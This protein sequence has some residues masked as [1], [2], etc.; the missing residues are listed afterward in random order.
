MLKQD[1]HMNFIEA[2]LLNTSFYELSNIKAINLVN[3]YTNQVGGDPSLEAF[4][5]KVESTLKNREIFLKISSSYEQLILQKLDEAQPWIFQNICKLLS[6]SESDKCT[7]GVSFSPDV[8][9][10]SNL[11]KYVSSLKERRNDLKAYRS[12][13][14]IHTLN[15]LHLTGT[16]KTSAVKFSS[17]KRLYEVL[18]SINTYDMVV[19][20]NAELTHAL[21]FKDEYF[22][23]DIQLKIIIRIAQTIFQQGSASATNFLVNL[24]E[25]IKDSSLLELIVSSFRGDWSDQHYYLFQ[26]LHAVDPDL[27]S[28]IQSKGDLVKFDIIPLLNKDL[29]EKELYNLFLLD[30]K[31]VLGNLSI[32]KNMPAALYRG[33]AVEKSIIN[34]ENSSLIEQ[35]ANNVSELN[36]YLFNKPSTTGMK[37][38]LRK[39]AKHGF[40]CAAAYLYNYFYNKINT[41]KK[42]SHLEKFSDLE[43]LAFIALNVNKILSIQGEPYIVDKNPSQTVK[44]W[45]D[46]A[47]VLPNVQKWHLMSFRFDKKEPK[48]DTFLD[49]Y[50]LSYMRPT[51]EISLDPYFGAN[52][53]YNP[54]DERGGFSLNT[55]VSL[56]KA[57]K[58]NPWKS[59]TFECAN[60]AAALSLAYLFGSDLEAA[61]ALVEQKIQES[62]AKD[63]TS[64]R[65]LK[66]ALHDAGQFHIPKASAE[67]IR[68]WRPYFV[69]NEKIRGYASYVLKFKKPEVWMSD[70]EVIKKVYSVM[71]PGL[72]ENLGEH[73]VHIVENG[74][75]K[76]V[77]DEFISLLPKAKTESMIPEVSIDQEGVRVEHLKPGDP[78]ALYI[79]ELSGCCQHIN[80]GAGDGAAKQSFTQPWCSVV[81]VKSDNNSLLAQAFIWINKKE[82][83]IVIDSL[84]SI[85]SATSDVIKNKVLPAMHDWV[86][87]MINQRGYNVVLSDTYYGVTSA[88]KRYLHRSGKFKKEVKSNLRVTPWARLSYTDFHGSG[89]I[90]S[91][92]E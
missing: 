48:F 92:T 65:V 51:D 23:N 34:I 72:P 66:K 46:L 18:F 73:A 88:L 19:A 70:A 33:W 52:S 59:T 21:F 22:D 47:K 74:W 35:I 12:L 30:N 89:V 42:I 15:W 39:I 36:Q 87:E 26:W 27:V 7:L 57:Y 62:T 69:R 71:I 86:A 11:I 6:I 68:Y 17:G 80:Y 24:Y 2:T 40:D 25:L 13:I 50:N 8:L 3:T 29:D 91:A 53:I 85:H 79:G 4:D 49:N 54:I 56:C 60:Q 58:V 45:F 77:I 1:T 9:M 75:R 82:D 55:Y 16:A 28:A 32:Y 63:K 43:K 44:G 84:E 14:L 81:A 90:Y 38:V 10:H 41:S 64:A 83:T 76:S 78:C 37:P 67:D 20:E 5:T 31:R 61:K